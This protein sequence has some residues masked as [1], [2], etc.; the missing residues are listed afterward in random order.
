[1]KPSQLFFYFVASASVLFFYE[2]WGGEKA[3]TV[4]C[5]RTGKASYYSNKFKGRRTSS[6]QKYHPDSLTCAHHKLPFGTLLEVTNL[7]NGKTVRVRVNDR[8]GRKS[9]RMVDLSMAAARQLE[10]IH[11]GVIPVRISCVENP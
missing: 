6:G 8:L 4:D 10:M 1:M 5:K 11:Q 2:S 3:A 9:K 7:S